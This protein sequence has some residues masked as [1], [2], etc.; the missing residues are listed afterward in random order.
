MIHHVDA[1][2]QNTSE[3][4]YEEY[5]ITKQHNSKN[6]HGEVETKIQSDSGKAF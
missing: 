5:E 3:S 4:K 1:M 2:V 6:K